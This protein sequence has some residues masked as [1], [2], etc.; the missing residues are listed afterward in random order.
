MG[1]S[2]LQ[3]VVRHLRRI[4]RPVTEP[5]SSDAELLARFAEESDESAFAEIVR[6]H[7]PLVWAMCRG[8]L[9]GCRACKK[10]IADAEKPDKVS[11]A[12]LP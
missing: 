7:G 5:P 6:R 12:N 2:S 10:M 1:T 9:S 4:A 11:P 3:T 8:R